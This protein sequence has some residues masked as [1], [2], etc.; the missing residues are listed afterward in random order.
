[1]LLAGLDLS[2]VESLGRLQEIL[3]LHVDPLLELTAAEQMH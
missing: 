3:D 2:L 1:M